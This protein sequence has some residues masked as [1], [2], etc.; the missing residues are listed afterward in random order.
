MEAD[1]QTQKR[2]NG[3]RDFL[4]QKARA[5][6]A[7]AILQRDVLL[8]IDA[9][10]EGE[11]VNLSS[12]ELREAR[13]VL[14]EEQQA[15]ARY[16]LA[17]CG[18][19]M[20]EQAVARGREVG[21]TEADETMCAAS[22]R[23]QELQRETAVAEVRRLLRDSCGGTCAERLRAQLALAASALSPDELAAAHELL[24][25]S[26]A[27]SKARVMLQEAQKMLR[28]PKK[29]QLLEAAILEAERAGLPKKEL[30]RAEKELESVKML[31]RKQQALRQKRSSGGG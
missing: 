30:R 13:Q 2:N 17:R 9:I 20:L 22:R 5:F 19:S 10:E 8:L 1:K 6:L 26:E 28:G 12:V 25:S 23:L 29:E 15:A 18:E 14:A 24:T 16:Q 31:Q 21:L 3:P 11:S 7:Q 27:K 4:S